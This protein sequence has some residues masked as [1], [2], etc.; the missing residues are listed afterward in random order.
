MKNQIAPASAPTLAPTFRVQTVTL[1]LGI[2][3]LRLHLSELLRDEVFAED[4]RLRANDAVYQSENATQLQ[5][6]QRNVERVRHER[7]LAQAVTNR[8]QR[9][10]TSDYSGE[11]HANLAEDAVLAETGLSYADVLS[12]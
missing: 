3:L 4:E 12:L 5:R 7:Q 2:S 9:G 1:Y 11:L 6:W 10:R 8:E